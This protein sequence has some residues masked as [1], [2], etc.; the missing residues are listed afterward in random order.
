MTDIALRPG[1]PERAAGHDA[2]LALARRILA[3]DEPAWETFVERYA[4]LIYS[5]VRRYLRTRDVDDVRSVLV[6]V[7]VSLRRT[8][9]A[10]YEGRAALSTWLT[11]VAR[12]EALEQVRRRFGRGRDVRGCE[13]LTAQE[14]ELFRLYH[15]EGVPAREAIAVL[16]RDGEAWTVDRLIASLRTVERKL[17]ER[18]LRRHAY[19]MHAQSVGAASGRLLE[20][21]DHVREEFQSGPGGHSP[22][23]HLMEREARRTA[24]RVSELIAELAPEER[25]ILTLRFERGWTARAIADELGLPGT[26]GVYTVL[27]RVVRR[28]RRWIGEDAEQ[29]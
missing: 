7:L 22:E 27:E 18:W 4:G 10:T 25:R 26:R 16:S 14:K 17:G 5:V 8:K 19:D 21:L 24:E 9:L 1:S 11:M 6:D 2:D 15:V 28:L 29:P 20:Y 12:S 23:Y 13:P 3:G